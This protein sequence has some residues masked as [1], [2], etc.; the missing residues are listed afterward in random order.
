MKTINKP[1]LVSTLVVDDEYIQA[2]R[3]ATVLENAGVSPC[4]FECDYDSALKTFRDSPA[5]IVVLDICLPEHS[6][7]KLLE[8]IRR[9]SSQEGLNSPF[10]IFVTGHGDAATRACAEKIG[11]NLFRE[12]PISDTDLLKAF[13]EAVSRLPEW[14]AKTLAPIAGTGVWSALMDEE[15]HQLILLACGEESTL[16]TVQEERL[17]ILQE[18]H[19]DWLALE[20]PLDPSRVDEALEEIRRLRQ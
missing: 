3:R 15:R 8:E 6:G 11:G 9:V 10:C 19:A 12:K 5:D 20:C 1:L 2:E 14:H 18:A 17:Q 13:N 7:F 16:T 4:S